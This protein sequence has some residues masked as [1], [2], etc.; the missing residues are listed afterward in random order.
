MGLGSGKN[1]FQIGYPGSKRH[2][3]LDP[4]RWWKHSP[5]VWL[6]WEG[7]RVVTRSCSTRGKLCPT[8][9]RWRAVEPSRNCC[10]PLPRSSRKTPD[11]WGQLFIFLTRPFGL[12]TLPDPHYLSFLLNLHVWMQ[13]CLTQGSILE[14]NPPHAPGPG[15]VKIW[16]KKP[17][18][19][20]R[21][22]RRLT[23]LIGAKKQLWI[24]IWYSFLLCLD[25]YFPPWGPAIPTPLRKPVVYLIGGK[26]WQEG[27]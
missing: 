8:M 18:I 4:Q 1:L 24:N 15:G 26:I 9:R 19:H 14:N 3:I 27:K 21:I 16:F 23:S 25:V 17:R 12:V 10:L 5:W 11:R 7:S 2:R 6:I 13:W 22:K 20:R